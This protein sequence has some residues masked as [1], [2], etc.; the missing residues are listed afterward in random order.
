MSSNKPTP[1]ADARMLF[2]TPW[3]SWSV[4]RSAMY[5]YALFRRTPHRVCQTAPGDVLTPYLGNFMIL[6]PAVY[7]LPPSAPRPLPRL[8]RSPQD[9]F[10]LV[11]LSSPRA[12]NTLS[13]LSKTDQNAVHPS[14]VFHRLVKATSVDIEPE[15]DEGG[16]HGDADDEGD[17][18]HD[19]AAQVVHKTEGEEKDGCQKDK[20]SKIKGLIAGEGD[21]GVVDESVEWVEEREDGAVED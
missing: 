3:A 11:T 8:S 12:T 7:A 5:A 17:P 10:L 1:F 18:E 14:K 9:M 16:P 15:A 19:L 2:T 13:F 21:D 4:V 20:V 6:S